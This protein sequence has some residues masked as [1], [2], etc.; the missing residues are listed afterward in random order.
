MAGAS[1]NRSTT[2][3][4]MAQLIQTPPPVRLTD[5]LALASGA[6]YH[7]TL[8]YES[9]KS[10]YSWRRPYVEATVFTDDELVGGYYCEFTGNHG[11]KD[12]AKPF[13]RSAGKM[14][15]LPLGQGEYG[16]VL[17][18]NSK[19]LVGV[20]LVDAERIPVKWT[21]DPLKG[22]AKAKLFRVGMSEG[23]AV[24]IA[25]DGTILVEAKE[26]FLAFG[27]NKSLAFK[28]QGFEVIGI[29]SKNRVWGN[30]RI[31]D[32]FP[33]GQS[34]TFMFGTAYNKVSDTFT[35]TGVNAK[36]EACGD[37]HTIASSE[38][39]GES[40][41]PVAFVGGSIKEIRLPRHNYS[42]TAAINDHGEVAGYY[43]LPLARK[44]PE[45]G[46]VTRTIGF[47]WR[48]G[49]VEKLDPPDAKMTRFTPQRIN[50][51]G[52]VIVASNH[53]ERVRLYLMR[54]R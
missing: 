53:P 11:E 7:T 29:D 1:R 48:N 20:I 15:W 27:P 38:R 51:A 25:H 3:K 13:V 2:M 10:D 18:G 30:Q 16:R 17:A 54:K 32:W 34:A 19:I 46:D 39:T 26:K 23:T 33:F 22:W 8:L 44:D 49:V 5:M 9:P 50:R 52:S 36:G 37:G 28:R 24:A 45:T 42:S 6:A 12:L 41:G 31:N 43:G 35:L 14:H 47:V 40:T 4:R 21:P